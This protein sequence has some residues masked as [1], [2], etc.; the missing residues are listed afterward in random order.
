MGG[1]SKVRSWSLL[2]GLG[3]SWQEG[4]PPSAGL[5]IENV[6]YRTND[7]SLGVEGRE[8]YALGAPDDRVF[9]RVSYGLGATDDRIF[10]RTSLGLPA[11]ADHISSRGDHKRCRNHCAR[12]VK[13]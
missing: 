11:T 2:A 7:F 5:K 6:T 3:G 10:T 8:P 1:G 9:A 4:T 13:S 12:C